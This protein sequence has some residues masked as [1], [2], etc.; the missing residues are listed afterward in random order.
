MAN[1]SNSRLTMLVLNAINVRY[2]E[3]DSN[4]NKNR[5]IWVDSLSIELRDAIEQLFM[6]AT[7]FVI[8]EIRLPSLLFE[9]KSTERDVSLEKTESL[10]DLTTP[11]SNF[12]LTTEDQYLNRFFTINMKIIRNARLTSVLRGSAVLIVRVVTEL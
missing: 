12:T 10:I 7:S 9:K 6:M 11:S 8:T 1:L 5:I 3:M 4:R 2:G